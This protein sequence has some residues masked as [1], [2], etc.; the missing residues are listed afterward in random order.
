MLVGIPGIG[1]FMQFRL[2]FLPLGKLGTGFKLLF[3]KM[4]KECGATTFNALMT[5]LSAYR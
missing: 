2:S 4:I 5:A 3:E 1:S